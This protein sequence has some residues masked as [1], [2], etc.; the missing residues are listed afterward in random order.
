MYCY[1]N[2]MTIFALHHKRNLIMKTISKKKIKAF[3]KSLGVNLTV[4]KTL[5][6]YSKSVPE[7]MEESDRILANSNFHF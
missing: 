4:D 6:K 7:K 2:K 3:A 5:G 1:L